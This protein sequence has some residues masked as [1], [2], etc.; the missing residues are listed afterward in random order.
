MIKPLRKYHFAI[1][2]LLA[3]LLPLFFIMAVVIRPSVPSPKVFP[4]NAFGAMIESNT[5]STYLV[6]IEVE[7]FIKAPS[8]VIILSNTTTELALG[9]VDGQGTYSFV[10]EKVELPATVK[11]WDAIHHRA[12]DSVPLIKKN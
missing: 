9:I 7:H 5:D 10:I 3:V 4:H 2:Q 8:C 11:L 12:I 1:W 6:T